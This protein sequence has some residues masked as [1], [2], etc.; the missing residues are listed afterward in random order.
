MSMLSENPFDILNALNKA[1]PSKQ[2]KAKTQKQRSH[3]N[4][5]GEENVARVH[6]GEGDRC[7]VDQGRSLSSSDSDTTHSAVTSSDTE[8]GEENISKL[9]LEGDNA[10]DDLG[11]GSRRVRFDLSKT[12]IIY[13]ERR[14]VS[15]EEKKLMRQLAREEYKAKQ[16]ARCKGLG[17][18]KKHRR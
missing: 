4:R 16:R 2:K 7:S 17:G 1:A 12:Q 5:R 15:K 14:N 11:A 10:D 8:S 9:T 13:I 3:S 18:G 6:L